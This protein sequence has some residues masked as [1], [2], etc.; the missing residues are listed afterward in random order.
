MKKKYII[1][2]L[3]FLLPYLD[4]QAAL[5]DARLPNPD[6]PTKLIIN[7]RI[8][9]KVNGTAIST[10]DVARK[11]DMLFYKQFPEYLTSVPARY[12]YYQANWK[13]VLEEL[14]HKELV[15][16]DAQQ[17]KIEVSNGDV[18]QEMETMFGP[19]I[20]DNLDKAGMTFEEAAKMVQGDIL[21]SRMLNYKVNAKALRLVTPSKVRQ[22]YEELI[23]NPENARP[24][25]WRYQV[26]TVR[27][28]N[29]KKTEETAKMV[30]KVIME[31]KIPLDQLTPYLKENKKLGPKGKVTVSDVIVNN[32][33]ELSEA[34]KKILK[35]MQPGMISQ[36]ASQ[37]SRTDKTTVYRIFY[38]KEMV[39]G[40]MP[41]YY[42]VENEI[43]EQML[44][45]VAD[46]ETDNYLSKLRNHF[47]VR[48]ED[49][50]AMIP[51]N[52]Q[53]FTLK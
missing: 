40:G 18:R 15:L 6:Q 42:E 53:P 28:R 12:Q 10:Y 9:A 8:L 35:D 27:D 30:Y 37:K 34:Y 1:F 32:E 20:I 41:S 13:A 44:N 29:P 4:I 39:S 50:N 17:S 31:E 25:L 38:L 7:N 52:Y 36:P 5:A 51:S 11:M 19:N 2:G 23:K 46:R 47:R 43:K 22:T 45:Q 14:I 33:T 26:I 49:L 48:E 3:L 16:A 21:I 24:N